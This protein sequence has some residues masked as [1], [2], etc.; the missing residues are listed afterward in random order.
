[1]ATRRLSTIAPQLAWAAAGTIRSTRAA[2]ARSGSPIT[3]ARLD[4]GEVDEGGVD[5]A[6][7]AVRADAEE[8]VGN[9]AMHVTVQVSRGH[10]GFDHIDIVANRLG[11]SGRALDRLDRVNR[12]RHRVAGRH[13]TGERQGAEQ[14]GGQVTRHW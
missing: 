13:A 14:D 4:R 11:A 12:G 7:G 3:V 9:A 1:M 10:V 2:S 5:A 8:I 6:G